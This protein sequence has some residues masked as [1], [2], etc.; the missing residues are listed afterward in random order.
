MVEKELGTFQS[1]RD[2]G[3]SAGSELCFWWLRNCKPDGRLLVGQDLRIT[4]RNG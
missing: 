3:V 4:Q 1:L 2:L